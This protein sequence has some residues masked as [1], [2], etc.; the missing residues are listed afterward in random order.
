MTELIPSEPHPP[1]QMPSYEELVEMKALGQQ[2]M[3]V[4]RREWRLKNEAM[5]ISERRDA[6]ERFGRAALTISAQFG[7]SRRFVLDSEPGSEQ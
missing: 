6:E 3:E 2:K 4:L 5:T 1:R 7:K